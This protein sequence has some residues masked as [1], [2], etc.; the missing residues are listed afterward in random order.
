MTYLE[1]A[2][3]GLDALPE[4]VDDELLRVLGVPQEQ[5]QRVLLLGAR[6][7]KGK[8]D[9]PSNN[10]ANAPRAERP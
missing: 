9:R 8:K 1:V 6:G 7:K 10:E 4:R 5:L 2:G 3:D